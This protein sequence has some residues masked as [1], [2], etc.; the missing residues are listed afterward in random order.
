MM[1]ERVLEMKDQNKVLLALTIFICVILFIAIALDESEMR[2]VKEEAAKMQE[3]VS[4]LL[5]ENANLTEKL[6]AQK[7][8]ILE[9]E[10]QLAD[11]QAEAQAYIYH[12]QSYYDPQYDDM[13][14]QEY[15]AMRES[16]ADYEAQN[17]Q[18]YGKYQLQIDMLGG[19]L[20]P[21]NQEETAERY[22]MERYGSWENAR[23]FWDNN[24]WY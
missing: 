14:A 15:I 10:E 8:K 3:T 1:L 6:N 12:P 22:V 7:Y 18:Y 4:T 5:A 9:L 11:T 21:E 23:E 19:D 2:K 17:G 24:G 16:G 20:S 13:N